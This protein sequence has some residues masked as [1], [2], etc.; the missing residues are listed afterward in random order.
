VS[1]QAWAADILSAVIWPFIGSRLFLWL[2][3]GRAK[4][5]HQILLSHLASWIVFVVVLGGLGWTEHSNTS[6]IW[7]TIGQLGWLLWDF[8]RFHSRA[9]PSSGV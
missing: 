2:L 9:A 3:R 8:Y 5:I 7:V 6:N 4:E 1:F